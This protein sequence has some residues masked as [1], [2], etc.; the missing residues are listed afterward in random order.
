MNCPFVCLIHPYLPILGHDISEKA[1]V[2]AETLGKKRN[3]LL[4]K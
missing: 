4:G 1:R 2:S 3:L